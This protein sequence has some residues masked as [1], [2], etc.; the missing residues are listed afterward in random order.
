MA[1]LL[2]KELLLRGD[3]ANVMV[4]SPGS[5]VDQWDEEM[6]EKFEL[7]F[8]MLTRDKMLHEGN[9]FARGGLWLTRLLGAQQRRNSGQSLRDRL[10]PN[11]LR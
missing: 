3:A 5:L 7:E 11:H 8:E 4:V 9:P 6:R 2:I 1:G 10:G